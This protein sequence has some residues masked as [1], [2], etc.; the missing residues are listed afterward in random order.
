MCGA[1]CLTYPD[2]ETYTGNF[3][4]FFR[5]G[6][7]KSTLTVGEVYEG[8]FVDDRRHGPGTNPV[9]IQY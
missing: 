1:G 8:Q 4:N 5:N 6:F 9:P 3:K 7:G 2:G